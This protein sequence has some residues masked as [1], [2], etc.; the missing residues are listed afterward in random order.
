MNRECMDRKKME[1]KIFKKHEET[2]RCYI[3]IYIYPPTKFR[4][5][6]IVES[7]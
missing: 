6:Y 3:Y 2:L 7:Y 4:L 1:I 5:N